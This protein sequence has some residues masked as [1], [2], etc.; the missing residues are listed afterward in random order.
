MKNILQTENERIELV[1][2]KC[3]VS[4]G[5]ARQYWVYKAMI[6]WRWV[7]EHLFLDLEQLWIPR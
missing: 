3:G 4:G 7:N 2:Q 1:F 6:N 5:R